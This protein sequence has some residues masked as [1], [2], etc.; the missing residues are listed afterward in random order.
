MSFLFTETSD[1]LDSGEANL[2]VSED[3]QPNKKNCQESNGYCVVNVMNK[4]IL[5]EHKFLF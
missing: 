2:D 3:E 1:K 5:L 4:P